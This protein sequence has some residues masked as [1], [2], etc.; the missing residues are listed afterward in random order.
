M[1]KL[2]RCSVGLSALRRCMTAP[3]NRRVYIL[4]TDLNG[5]FALALSPSLSLARLYVCV[6]VFGSLLDRALKPSEKWPKNAQKCVNSIKK[7]KWKIFV[8]SE[9]SE[10]LWIASGKSS[11]RSTQSVFEKYKVRLCWC[12]VVAL[13]LSRSHK[14]SITKQLPI[15][16][17]SSRRARQ[18]QRHTHTCRDMYVCV[19]GCLIRTLWEETVK[20]RSLVRI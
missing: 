10:K 11:K 1:E 15:L 2:R 14:Q 18:S 9:T 5:A 16:A 19:C 6:S 7:H 4:L 8:E 3:R 20:S 17:K 12:V 13:L